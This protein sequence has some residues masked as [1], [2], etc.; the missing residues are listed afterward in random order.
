MEKCTF[1]KLEIQHDFERT[2]DDL[3]TEFLA[4]LDKFEPRKKVDAV[5][6]L[7]SRL[8][9][10]GAFEAARETLPVCVPELI[11]TSAWL[12]KTRDK[13]TDKDTSATA[14]IC[15]ITL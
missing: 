2:L 8:V 1:Y 7:A 10:F 9:E 12:E 6:L 11:L 14:M 5:L 13:M 3:A 15:P 4:N